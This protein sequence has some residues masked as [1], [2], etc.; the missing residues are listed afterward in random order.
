MKRIGLLIISSLGLLL[1]LPYSASAATAKLEV[2]GWLPYWR[3]ASSTADALPHL[4]ELK[5]VNPFGLSVRSDGT[6]A[7]IVL[8]IDEEPWKSLIIAAKAKKERVIPT[9]MWSDTEAI[10][11]ILSNR[12]SRNKLEDDITALACNEGFDGIDID[13]AGKLAEDKQYFSSF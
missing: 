13:F 9:V 7:D 1:V 12:E 10:H 5:E 11:R 8:N 2:S 4:G 3:A 6:L